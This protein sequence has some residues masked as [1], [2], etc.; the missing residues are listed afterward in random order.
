[1]SRLDYGSEPGDD[2]ITA[3]HIKVACKGDGSP[4]VVDSFILVVYPPSTETSYTAWVTRN[5][6]RGSWWTV[7]PKPYATLGSGNSD[8]EPAT[9]SP[10]LWQGVS[11]SF[12]T[13]HPGASFQMRSESV[14]GH[15][16]QATYNAVGALILS[17]IG[18]G[19]ADWA[20]AGLLTGHSEEDV[21]PYIWAAQL[22]GNPIT[23]T[24]FG[25]GVNGTFMRQANRLDQYLSLRPPLTGSTIPAGTCP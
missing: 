24:F 13:Y 16:H 18:A 14:A 15:G 19:T 12:L 5:V 8:P 2:E 11:T 10:Q 25:N 17:G 9:C 22:D 1:M 23:Q 4:Q 21:K 20:E 7:L 3:L 6:A